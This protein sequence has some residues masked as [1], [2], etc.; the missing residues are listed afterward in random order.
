MLGA[1]ILE[2]FPMM[3]FQLLPSV[4]KSMVKAYLILVDNGDNDGKILPDVVVP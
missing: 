3:C 1:Q 2:Y 4:N